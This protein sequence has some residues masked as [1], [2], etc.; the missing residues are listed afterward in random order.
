MLF[1]L[2]LRPLSLTEQ[3]QRQ[4]DHHQKLTRNKPHGT[5]QLQEFGGTVMRLFTKDIF[6]TSKTSPGTRI[7]AFKKIIKWNND[8]FN[9]QDVFKYSWNNSD[10]LNGAFEAPEEPLGNTYKRSFTVMF[11][12]SAQSRRNVWHMIQNHTANR[13]SV[14]IKCGVLL[15]WSIYVYLCDITLCNNTM[16]FKRH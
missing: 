10:K 14:F 9:F 8:V 5:P 12:D 7:S 15:N 4:E 3:R 16:L 11:K 6:S 2:K 13:R 1:L